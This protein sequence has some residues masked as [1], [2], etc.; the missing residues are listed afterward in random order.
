MKF[1][2]FIAVLLAVVLLVPALAADKQPSDDELYDQ[3]KRRLAND[4][5]VK[6]GAL[7]VE[8]KDGMVTIRGAVDQEKHKQ[9]ADKLVRKVKGVKGVHNQLTVTGR[10]PR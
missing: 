5:E 10:G 6:G 7:D 3:V 2:T 9:R 1:K 8:V 4:A